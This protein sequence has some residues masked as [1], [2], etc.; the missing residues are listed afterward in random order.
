MSLTNYEMESRLSPRPN[1]KGAHKRRPYEWWSDKPL[2][3]SQLAS[4]QSPRP[5]P[6]GAHKG[7]PYKWSS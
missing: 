5:V 6:T 4:R 1:P 7:R 2:A 3:D